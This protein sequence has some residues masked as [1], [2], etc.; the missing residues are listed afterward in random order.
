MLRQVR[1]DHSPMVAV[2]AV[3]EE[4]GSFVRTSQLSLRKDQFLLVAFRAYFICALLRAFGILRRHY[5]NVR[6][7]L[8][9]QLRSRLGCSRHLY[10]RQEAVYVSHELLI[11]DRA[12]GS[13][14]S[15]TLVYQSAA[16]ALHRALES[17]G[18][19]ISAIVAELDSHRSYC[20]YLF[21]VSNI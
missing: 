1:D 20:I 12:R 21:F 7:E 10:L 2:Q 18:E 9:S 15:L 5:L 16:V 3:V 8:V 4:C 6:V 13:R 19:G 17:R 14:S 11:E